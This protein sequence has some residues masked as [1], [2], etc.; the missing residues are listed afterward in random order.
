MDILISYKLTTSN[1]DKTKANQLYEI[2]KMFEY[3]WDD[4]L[5]R[6]KTISHKKLTPYRLTQA[7]VKNAASKYQAFDFF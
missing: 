6:Y 5:A 7:E 4:M 3:R 1:D 2:Y